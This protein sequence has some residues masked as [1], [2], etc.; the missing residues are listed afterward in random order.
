MRQLAIALAFLLLLA[1]PCYGAEQGVLEYTGFSEAAENFPLLSSWPSAPEAVVRKALP[2]APEVYLTCKAPRAVAVRFGFYTS[3]PLFCSPTRR[4]D[5]LVPG[6]SGDSCAVL[7]SYL[8]ASQC[9]PLRYSPQ[10]DSLWA[11]HGGS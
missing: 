11:E 7:G 5:R 6:V 8:D 2:L 3:S 4:G 9:L 10:S 1:F